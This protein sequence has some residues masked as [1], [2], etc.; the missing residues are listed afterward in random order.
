[1][2]EITAIEL[3]N[4]IPFGPDHELPLMK[5]MKNELTNPV[6]PNNKQRTRPWV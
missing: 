5:I 3:K 6:I 1:M 2:T 4:K